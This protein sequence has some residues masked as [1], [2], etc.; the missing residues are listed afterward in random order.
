ME[1]QPLRP[2]DLC[3]GDAL[4][5]MTRRD[6]A[7]AADILDRGI[8]EHGADLAACVELA[9]A[10]ALNGE[11]VK[12]TG[13]LDC[14]VQL[15][16]ATGSG[17][18][19]LAFGALAM[20]KWVQGDRAAAAAAF[21]EWRGRGGFFERRTETAPATP[22]L[23]MPSVLSA[24]ERC[25]IDW[26]SVLD[27]AVSADQ[28]AVRFPDGT[29]L[30]GSTSATEFN[31]RALTYAFHLDWLFRGCEL[32]LAN[33]GKLASIYVQPVPAVGWATYVIEAWGDWVGKLHDG[34]GVHLPEFARIVSLDELPVTLWFAR[35]ISRRAADDLVAVLKR[36]FASVRDAGVAGEGSVFPSS[37]T[38]RFYRRAAG[39]TADFTHSGSY[40]LL[41]LIVTILAFCD[42]CLVERIYAM[43]VSRDVLGDAAFEVE[44]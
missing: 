36:W 41:W 4:A 37:L 17:Y 19:G 11:Y 44:L 22:T 25:G 1:S 33:R 12:G 16:S 8:A 9:I 18:G 21:A 35:P 30:L 13:A 28:P 15:A 42:H 3:V 38:V 7:G 23:Y 2:I 10:R 6:F 14:A 34:F 26:P 24:I 40:T 20:Y 31:D 5:A 43:P 27:A 32:G 29:I 39:F